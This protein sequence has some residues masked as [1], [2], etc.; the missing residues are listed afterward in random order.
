MERELGMHNEKESLQLILEQVQSAMAKIQG[1]DDYSNKK[2]ISK[3]VKEYNAYKKTKLQHFRF[4]P[5]K[6]STQFG[7]TKNYMSLSNLYNNSFSL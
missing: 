6:V 1:E 3:L 7:E 2:K 5:E 4:N